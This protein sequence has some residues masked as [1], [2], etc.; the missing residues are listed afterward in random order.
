VAKRRSIDP[1]IFK[2]PFLLKQPIAARYLYHYVIEVAADDEGRFRADPLALARDCFSPADNV[3]PEAVEALLS[4]LSG[5]GGVLLLYRREGETFGFLRGWYEHQRIERRYREESSLPPPPVP[6]RCWEQ[7]D[8]LRAEYANAKG[9]RDPD[10]AQAR[11]AIR[12]HTQQTL[13]KRRRVTGESRENHARITCESRENHARITRLTGLDR[14]GLEGVNTDQVNYSAPE[15]PACRS[16]QASAPDGAPPSLAPES[17]SEAEL[18]PA[19]QRL[20]P[21]PGAQQVE[22]VNFVRA[23]PLTPHHVRALLS[24]LWGPDWHRTTTERKPGVDWPGELCLLWTDPEAPVNR[25]D[26]LALL[27]RYKPRRTEHPSGWWA[28]VGPRPPDGPRDPI[29]VHRE[30]A[31]WDWNHPWELPTPAPIQRQ[32]SRWEELIFRL[33]IARDPRLRE[34]MDAYHAAHIAYRDTKDA[35]AFPM[36]PFPPEEGNVE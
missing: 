17:G 3:T 9:L 8:A 31:A 16:R 25:E 22:E 12:W 20:T 21:G 5:K 30:R 13:E 36:P 14:T 34:V 11:E 29:D 18:A 4:M 35:E 23:N 32:C 6:I 28:R 24:L 10:K 15:P 2:H 33:T 19:P 26:C 27:K 7:V 1:N